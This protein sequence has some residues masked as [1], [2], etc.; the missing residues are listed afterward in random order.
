MW[1]HGS[2]RVIEFEQAAATYLV[3]HEVIALVDAA[4][5]VPLYVVRGAWRVMRRS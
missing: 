3:T 4:G 2:R 1:V 5:C